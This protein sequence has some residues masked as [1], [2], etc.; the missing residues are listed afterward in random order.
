MKTFTKIVSL[1]LVVFTLSSFESDKKEYVVTPVNTKVFKSVEK[2]EFDNVTLYKVSVKISNAS[3]IKGIAK[4]EELIPS[5]FTVTNMFTDFG[6]AVFDTERAKVT[7]LS[8][9]GRS[10]VHITYFLKGEL[11]IQPQGDSKFSFERGDKI[12]TIEV[13]NK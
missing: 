10:D 12:E 9:N 6:K 13:L 5:G 4:F 3:D 7:F 1:L 11:A 8:L 2:L